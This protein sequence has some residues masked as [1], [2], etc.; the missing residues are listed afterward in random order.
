MRRDRGRDA[1]PDGSPSSVCLAHRPL[2][3][4]LEGALRRAL[5]LAVLVIA[6]L[7]C[8]GLLRVDPLAG[9]LATASELAALAP[10]SVARWTEAPPGS[11]DLHDDG[12]LA[13]LSEAESDVDDLDDDDVGDDRAAALDL[14]EHSAAE[15]RVPGPPR[16]PE[17]TPESDPSRLAL[18]RGFARGPPA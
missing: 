5:E 8:V 3:T 1:S 10:V 12:L 14:A 6:A 11:H 2:V 13:E 16:S 9:R 18:G 17:R 7:A 15:L 4:R